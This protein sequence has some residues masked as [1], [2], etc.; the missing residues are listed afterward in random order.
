[1]D[2]RGLEEEEEESMVEEEESGGG[3]GGGGLGRRCWKTGSI[4]M[5]FCS[6]SS[7]EDPRGVT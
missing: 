7:S 3:A 6:C 2:R 1:M 5:G 4:R